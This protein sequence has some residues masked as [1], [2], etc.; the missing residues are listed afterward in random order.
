MKLLNEFRERATGGPGSNF[1]ASVTPSCGNFLK[2]ANYCTS[3]Q[4]HIRLFNYTLTLA[5]VVQPPYKSLWSK[6]PILRMMKP[7]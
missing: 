4:N 5:V 3:Q 2:F 6:Q 7:R 1:S